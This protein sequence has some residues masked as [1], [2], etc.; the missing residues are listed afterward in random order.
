MAC[1]QNIPKGD[2][3]EFTFS[4][5][6]TSSSY[7]IW[8]HVHYIFHQHQYCI[9]LCRHYHVTYVYIEVVADVVVDVVVDVWMDVWMDGWMDGWMN[10]G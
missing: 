4:S 9:S 2:I 1:F 10:V 3:R 5:D 7:L 6:K 8:L